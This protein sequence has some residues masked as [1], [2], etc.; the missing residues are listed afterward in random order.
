MGWSSIGSAWS[1]ASAIA[2]KAAEQAKT[3]AEEQSKHLPNEQAKKW[4]ETAMGY[5][6]NAQLDKL[7]KYNGLFM[8][9]EDAYAFM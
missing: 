6:K 7:G 5:V 9:M 2:A 1:T 3:I 4:S 8:Y